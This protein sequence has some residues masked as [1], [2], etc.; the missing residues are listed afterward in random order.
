MIQARYI[1]TEVH[2]PW[3]VFGV[4]NMGRLRGIL[5]QPCVDA[6]AQGVD[7]SKAALA[8]CGDGLGGAAVWAEA[9][10]W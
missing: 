5:L 7:L 2:T 10:K 9:R 4:L 1:H 8:Q 3:T 6:A